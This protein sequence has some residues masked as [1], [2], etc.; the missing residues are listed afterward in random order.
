[1]NTGAIIFSFNSR[2]IDYAVMSLVAG[3][4]VKKNLD[5]PVTLITDQ[6][7]IDWMKES[8]IYEN[9]ES[10][11]EKFILVDRPK[12]YNKRLLNDG[13]QSSMVPFINSYRSSAWDL[14]PYDK[15]LLIDSDFL[16]LSDNLKNYLR[17]DESIM[18]SS[19]INDIRDDRIG[20]LDKNVSDVGVH[21]SW[22]TTIIFTKNEESKIFFDTV[23][24]IEKEYAMFADLYRYDSRIYRN[25]IAFSVAKHIY[26]GFEED[27][28]NY[29]PPVLT[30]YDRDML[31]DTVGDKLVFLISKDTGDFYPAAINKLDI[32]VMNKQSI[33][34]NSNKL[35]EF[36]K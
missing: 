10:V 29:L 16:I 13:N 8:K 32:H 31:I 12:E 36:I 6:S 15:T 4:F 25:D 24:L 21:L 22:A 19:A 18:I 14:T 33:I 28:T 30:I 26:D 5:I 20:F 1:M 9:A 7:T 3:S 23:K 27:E 2:D 17:L 11:F 35:L 34:R